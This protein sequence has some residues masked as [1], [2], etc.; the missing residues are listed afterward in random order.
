M[1]QH[2]LECTLGELHGNLTVFQVKKM[3]ESMFPHLKEAVL[4]EL[5]VGDCEAI[6]I[7]KEP[8]KTLQEI[9]CSD[10]ARITI[11]YRLDIPDALGHGALPPV[12]MSDSE[13]ASVLHLMS[14]Y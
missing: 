6:S 10:G 12:A 13:A 4:L 2:P 8:G 3:A 5:K 7:L 14:D 11:F 1:T 9:G